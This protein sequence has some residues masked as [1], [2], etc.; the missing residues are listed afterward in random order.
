MWARLSARK[1]VRKSA[2]TSDDDQRLII[3]CA[4][5]DLSDVKKSLP[6]H[7]VCLEERLCKDDDKGSLG[8]MFLCMTISDLIIIDTTKNTSPWIWMLIDRA[9]AEGCS[10]MYVGSKK[11]TGN[12]FKSQGKKKSKWCKWISENLQNL[13]HRKKVE[14]LAKD[15]WFVSS[16]HHYITTYLDRDEPL[17]KL[18]WS[19]HRVRI[20]IDSLGLNSPPK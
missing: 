20:L 9:C 1:S 5:V 4:N 16:V 14:H 11:K 15:T 2:G 7:C 8:R 6:P 3:Y 19:E 13:Y 18:Y 17:K 10:V 12:L